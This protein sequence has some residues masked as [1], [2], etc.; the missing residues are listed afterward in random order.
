MREIMLTLLRELHDRIPIL[1]DDLYERH[2]GA[3]A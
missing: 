3:A 2:V 1:F